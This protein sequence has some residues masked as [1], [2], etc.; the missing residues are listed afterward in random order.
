M[1]GWVDERDSQFGGGRGNGGGDG[2]GTLNG[3]CELTVTMAQWIK[4]ESL[5]HLVNA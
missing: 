4:M 3:S 1:D 2:K 5:Y